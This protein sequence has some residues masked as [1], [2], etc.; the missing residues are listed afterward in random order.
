MDIYMDIYGKSHVAA[1]ILSSSEQGIIYKTEEPNILLKLKWDPET[2]EIIKDINYNEK[3]DEIRILPIPK[4]TNLIL[5]QAILK[6]AVGYTMK[7]LDNMESFEKIFFYEDKEENKKL[8]NGWLRKIRKTNIDLEN[9]FKQYI[10]SGGI[11]KRIESYLKVACILS[12]I[13]ANGLVYCNVSDKNMF[14][15]KDLDKSNVCLIDCDNID[16]MK[17][18]KEN[19]VWEKGGFGAPEIIAG[20]GNTMYSDA[21]SFAI[22]LFWTLTKKHPFMG[23]AIDE[24]LKGEDFL[25]FLEEDYAC[26]GQFAWI[27]DEKDKSN[28]SENGL[29]YNIFLSKKLNAYFSS[30]FSEKGRKNIRKRVTMPEWSYILAKESDSIIRCKNCNMDYYGDDFLNCPWCDFENKIICVKSKKNKKGIYVENWKFKHEM[31]GYIN[32][33]LR[34]LSG[35][36]NNSIEEKAFQIRCTEKEIEIR[37]LSRW[38]YFS[39]IIDDKEKPIYGSTIIE[40]KNN[41]E[42]YATYKKNNIRYKIEIEV[43]Q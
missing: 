12:N 2:Q 43:Q 10:L 27:G 13:H 30:V 26:T 40:N 21:Y 20:K 38:Y 11:R 41:I 32:V 22:S 19:N 5:P 9:I 4:K 33:P 14:V 39:I 31:Y 29:P 34:I 36:N 1:S 23:R 8:D 6:D 17:K 42:I 18:T 28:H 3:F 16:Y 15:S 25:D 35:F 7:I 37:E 24:S